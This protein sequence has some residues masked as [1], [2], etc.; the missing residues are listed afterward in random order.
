MGGKNRLRSAITLAALLAVAMVSPASAATFSN[1][2]PI[3]LNPV[4]ASPA[5]LYPSTIHVSGL[6]NIADVNVTL[7]KFGAAEPADFDVML[8]S[9]DGNASVLM[10]DVPDG[11]PGCHTPVSG[12][13]LT[14]DDEAP[15]PIPGQTTLLSGTY[16]PLDNEVTTSGCGATAPPRP[17][18]YRPPA[19]DEPPTPRSGP[20][21][22]AIRTATGAST[23]SA[24]STATPARSAA[25]GA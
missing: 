23:S 17:D 21:P 2:A 8:G 24:T 11:A 7:H 3:S 6:E 18:T 20:S 25:A 22:A 14:F 13:E 19:P 16:Q 9:P 12:L 15:N 5:L 4:I 1:P 10:S